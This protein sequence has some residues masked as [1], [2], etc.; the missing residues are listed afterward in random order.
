MWRSSY[1]R[2]RESFG[3]VF[4]T[5]VAVKFDGYGWVATLLASP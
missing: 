1:G 5:L 3:N 4:V 2:G